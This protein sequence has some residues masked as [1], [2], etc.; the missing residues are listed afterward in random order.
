VTGSGPWSWTCAGT[1]GGANS[2]VCNATVG[3]NTPPAISNFR[4]AAGALYTNSATVSLSASVSEAIQKYILSENNSQ[5]AS[6]DSRW[7]AGST[8]PGAYT[9]LGSLTDG[10]HTIYSWAMDIAGNI[11]TSAASDSITVDTTPPVINNTSISPTTAYATSRSV[12][13]TRNDVN[14]RLFYYTTTD[15]TCSVS[16]SDSLF[17]NYNGSVNF[18]SPDDN[19]KRVC[20][21]LRDV[22]GNPTYALSGEISGIIPSDSVILP[23]GLVVSGKTYP[24]VDWATANNDCSLES[25]RLPTSSELDD[26]YN[27]KSVLSISSGRYWGNEYN[28]STANTKNFQTSSS[29]PMYKTYLY[30]ARCVK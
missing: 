2:N 3:D 29:A 12:T 11:S 30:Y 5:P 22:A 10:L 19:G 14:E 21:Q 17:S 18:Y 24:S 8:L 13:A 28:S 23:S 6:G 26:M 27:N 4:L 7:I 25:A 9:T 20:F 1:S 16:L 15:T